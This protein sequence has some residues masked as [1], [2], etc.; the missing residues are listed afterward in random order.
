MYS[1]LILLFINLCVISLSY[2]QYHEDY[3]PQLHY[4]PPKGWNND[5]NGLLYHKG[6]YHLFYQFYPNDT[7]PGPMH[8]GHAT[9]PDLF[10]W[11][12]LPIALYPQLKGQEDIWSGS[13]IADTHNV[14]G[15]APGGSPNTTLIAIFT[16]HSA[17]DGVQSQWMAYSLDNGLNWGYYA[18]NPI[19][20]DPPKVR[21]FRDPKI[22]K[23][24]DYY[25]L[26]L[27]VGDHVN[28]Y[29]SLNMKEW[30][31]K[32]EYG[33]KVGSHEGVW[34][35]VDLFPINATID[36][37]TVEKWVLTV[38]TAGRTQYFIG[39][40]D[41]QKF[42]NDNPDN[43]ILWVDYGPE[44]YA[45]VTYN[46]EDSGRRVFIAWMCNFGYINE[47]PTSVW[48][49]GMTLPRDLSLINTA[50]PDS[51]L[52]L[53]SIPAPEILKLNQNST[54]ISGGVLKANT[55]LSI[56]PKVASKLVDI[57]LELDMSGANQSADRFGV[58]FKGAK[59][60]LRVYYT[61]AGNKFVIDRSG[62]GRHEFSKNFMLTPDAPRLTTGPVVSMRLVLDVSSVEL[63]ADSG[64]TVMTGSFYST[65]NLTA[66]ISLFYESTDNTKQLKCN[67]ININSLKSIWN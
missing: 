62:A 27:A 36:G 29:N 50:A 47:V 37:K 57:E 51:K 22:F 19:I 32:Q 12:T 33:F 2:S 21:D 67:D 53:A 24:G 52:R 41:G 13:A 6:T 7:K 66:N 55:S 42:T 34:E 43:L 60:W 35:C 46:M 58:E 30:Q 4:P 11:Q 18:K 3:R 17:P 40:F 59:D 63:Y 48:R 16:G 9:S 56:V 54:K 61:G 25:A 10:H 28:I 1:K 8:W 39:T 45:G 20:P 5:P 15:F 23:Y 44:S 14:T 49:G 64:L 26:V 38:N 65:D 31:L